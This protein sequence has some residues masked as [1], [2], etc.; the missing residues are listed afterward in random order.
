MKRINSPSVEESKLEFFMAVKSGNLTKTKSMY[1]N[2]PF[3]YN[4][5]GG[6]LTLAV[7]SGNLELVKYL[8][9]EGFLPDEEETFASA[10][11]SGFLDILDYLYTNNIK[12]NDELACCWAAHGNKLE[13]IKYLINKGV[14][15]TSSIFSSAIET[16]QLD[17]IRYLHENHCPYEDGSIV[18]AVK[19]DR[20]GY[21]TNGSGLETIKY[22]HELGYPLTSK[23]FKSAIISNLLEIAEYLYVNNSPIDT[24]FFAKAASY[25]GV[26][27]ETLRYLLTKV[28]DLLQR[29][30][31]IYV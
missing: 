8:H 10:A 21:S 2:E 13:A 4:K 17:I 28:P 25:L 16:G 30:I 22:L 27:E 20:D 26:K 1:E 3:I 7:N 23:T 6:Y 29:K 12:R 9:I 5:D 18:Y 24:N 15:F 19:C 14:P 31:K 11:E